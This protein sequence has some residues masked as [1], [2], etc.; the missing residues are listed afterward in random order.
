MYFKRH[1]YTHL[2]MGPLLR[3][4]FPILVIFLFLKNPLA[5]LLKNIQA[6]FSLKDKQDGV[7]FLNVEST[8]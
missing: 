4:N 2:V 1:I 5:K 8:L 3:D 7:G 6:F